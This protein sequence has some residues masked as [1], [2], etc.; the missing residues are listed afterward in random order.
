MQSVSDD[1]RDKKRLDLMGTEFSSQDMNA[2][3]LVNDDGTMIRSSC[4]LNPDAVIFDVDTITRL[5]P[6]YA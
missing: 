3:P 4:A 1:E 2:V 6:A 5:M